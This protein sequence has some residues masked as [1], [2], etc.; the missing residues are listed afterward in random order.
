[1]TGSFR[2]I[3]RFLQTSWKF[4]FDGALGN[5]DN[6]LVDIPFQN[7]SHQTGIENIQ[8]QHDSVFH[9][10]STKRPFDTSERLKFKYS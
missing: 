4:L 9:K 1:M 10:Y 7:I 3:V 2:S 8:L 6:P 5:R